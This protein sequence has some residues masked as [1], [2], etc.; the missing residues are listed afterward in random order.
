MDL[1]MLEKGGSIT[2]LKRQAPLTIQN[3]FQYEGKRIQ[4]IDYRA[5]FYYRDK[6][7]TVVVEDVKGYD[8]KNGKFIQT[9]AFRLKWKLLKSKYP[10]YHFVLY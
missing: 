7:G 5:D 2:E 3:A 4:K 9:E 6:S 1:Q 10:E 8:K